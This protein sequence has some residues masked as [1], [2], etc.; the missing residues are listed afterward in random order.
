MKSPL[1]ILL[2]TFCFAQKGLTA[3]YHISSPGARI[4]VVSGQGEL[5]GFQFS[6]QLEIQSDGFTYAARQGVYFFNLQSFDSSVAPTDELIHVFTNQNKPILIQ[7]NHG[8]V[9]T[10]A[11]D[12]MVAYGESDNDI[13]IYTASINSEGV[14]EIEIGGTFEHWHNIEAFGFTE[15]VFFQA[16]F[17]I[18]QDTPDMDPDPQRYVGIGEHMELS[19]GPSVPEINQ[20]LLCALGVVVCVGLRRTR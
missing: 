1:V 13:R 6:N 10:T 14:I 2:C 18:H 9:N 12:G 15:P 19:F 20:S 11:P 8:Y 16:M 17:R 7:N 4:E 3:D 5:Y